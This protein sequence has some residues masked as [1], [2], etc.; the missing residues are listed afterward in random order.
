MSGSLFALALLLL[1]AP[2]SASVIGSP[3]NLTQVQG[4]NVSTSGVVDAPGTIRVYNVAP[5]GSSGGGSVY[6]ASGTIS[7]LGAPIARN[8]PVETSTSATTFSIQLLPP[9]AYRIALECSTSCTNTDVLYIGWG[10]IAASIASAPIPP[11]SS[12]QPPAVSTVALQFIA[13]TST[14]TINCTEYKNQ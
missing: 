4:M 10:T 13:N 3:V 11:C 2:A 5:G 12:W 6:V 7:I 14:Q 8:V 9:N 1:Q